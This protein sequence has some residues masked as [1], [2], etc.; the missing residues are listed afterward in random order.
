MSRDFSCSFGSVMENDV[1]KSQL[2]SPIIGRENENMDSEA[3]ND[4]QIN[5]TD[6]RDSSFET[7]NVDQDLSV[8]DNKSGTGEFVDGLEHLELFSRIGLIR[9][10][11]GG[12][13]QSFQIFSLAMTEKCG[14][15]AN[16]RHAWYSTSMDEMCKIASPGFGQSGRPENSNAYGVG[17]YFFP[18][19]SSIDWF[20]E[21]SGESGKTNLTLGIIFSSNINTFKV[22]PSVYHCFDCQE[23]KILRLT[24]VQ[25]V[26]Q[27]AG[28][29][30][31]L[32][33]IKSRRGNG[34][35]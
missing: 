32:A 14:G 7:N 4:E 13:L 21:D 31:L 15:N 30:F 25:R 22:L 9:L 18:E 33:I 1:Q 10:E 28:D 12:R 20:R 19:D 5:H 6:T 34:G 29:K 8:A 35:H 11:E 16:I 17:I 24:L 26:R 23:N 3:S 2:S 27:I